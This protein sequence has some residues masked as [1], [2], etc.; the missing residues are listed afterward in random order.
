MDN[1]L[2][3]F[4]LNAIKSSTAKEAKDKDLNTENSFGSE[5]DL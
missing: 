3:S 2:V 4:H 1:L 5:V